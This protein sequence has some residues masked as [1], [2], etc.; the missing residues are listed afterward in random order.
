MAI[1]ALF[2]VL[3]VAAPWIAPYDPF[4]QDLSNALS[5]PSAEHL[6]GAD[7]YGRDILS[8]VIYGTRTALIAII[9][10]DGLA[11]AVGGALGLVAGFAG[12]R[13]DTRDDAP[14]RRAAGVPLP[15]AG[16]DHRRRARA[17]A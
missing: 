17:R 5:P 6:F 15:A 16:A 12:G 8:R 11:L 10:A 14:G 3:T 7:Q 4:D 2:L 9:V 13:I 1:A